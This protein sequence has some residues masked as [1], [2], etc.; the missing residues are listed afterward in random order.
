MCS[1]KRDGLLPNERQGKG[2]V[3][4]FIFPEMAKY[5]GT[6]VPEAGVK[7]SGLTNYVYSEDK[8]GF[9]IVCPGDQVAAFCTMFQPHFGNPALT[10][11]NGNR[12]A[13][14]VYSV[15]QTGLAINCGLDNGVVDGVRTQVT[16]L[17]AVKQAAL[18]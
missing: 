17:V 5:G 8:D 12:P 3:S 16:Q 11:T 10:T 9:Q 15:N 13:S 4:I 6:N 14:F 7:A 1:C 18:K 2:D